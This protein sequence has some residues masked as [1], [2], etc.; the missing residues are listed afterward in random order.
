MPQHIPSVEEI[1]RSLAESLARSDPPSDPRTRKRRV[2]GLTR[3]VPRFFCAAIG[4]E[5]PERIERYERALRKLA[6]EMFES[7]PE[8]LELLKTLERYLDE[9]QERYRLRSWTDETDLGTYREF[10]SDE[11]MWEFLP[12]E[13][14]GLLDDEAARGLIAHSNEAAE[15]HEVFAVESDDGVIGQVRLQ[16]DSDPDPESAEISYWIG[17]PFWGQ[18]GAT[19]LV[20]L[21]TARSFAEYSKIQRIFAR[22]LKGNEGSLKV[23][24]RAG[25]RRED[26]DHKSRKKGDRWLGE[27]VLSVVRPDYE[28]LL[29]QLH[30]DG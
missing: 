26:Y 9:A 30:S 15:R 28:P 3:S 17:R 14:P 27:H 20:P 2:W 19:R 23:L 29:D 25:Y 6:M 22:V 1:F 5:D 7:L 24:E 8:D 13:Y 11:V 16:F 12:E 18:G 10:L 21:Y 4:D